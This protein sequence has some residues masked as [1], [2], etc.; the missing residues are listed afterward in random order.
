MML[1]SCTCILQAQNARD[2][3]RQ[4]N[5]LFHQ[6]QFTKA[7]ISYR[8]AIEKEPGST[9]AQFNL[10]NAL[11][12]Q[13]KGPKAIQQYNKALQ[14]THVKIKLAKIHHNIGEIYQMSQQYGPAI[15]AYKKSLYNNPYDNATRYNLALCQKMLKNQPQSNKNNKNKNKKDKNKDKNKQNKD[16]KN[17]D[18]QNKNNQDKN[19]QDKQPQKN[20]MSKENAEQMLN[21]ALQDERNTQ[22]NMKKVQSGNKKLEKNW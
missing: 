17:K 14:T 3:I 22:Q 8:K 11:L 2:Y 1:L 9:E 18:Q 10:G 16:Q 15:Q 13:S 6:K 7:E 20:Q 21:A 5:S 4:G 12:M 19:Q